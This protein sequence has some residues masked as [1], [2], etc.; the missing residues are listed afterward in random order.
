MNFL[1]QIAI[2]GIAIG[3][4]YSLVALSFSFPFAVSRTVN[5]SQ[6]QAVMLG[7]VVYFT[8]SKIFALGAFLSFVTVVAAGVL[9]GV[10]VARIAI[11]P[12]VEKPASNGSSGWLLSTIAIGIVVENLALLV[13]GSEARSISFGVDGEAVTFLDLRVQQYDA[14]IILVGVVVAVGLEYAI[15]T[16]KLGIIFR[17]VSDCKAQAE[18]IGINTTQALYAAYA[19]STAFAFVSGILIAPVFNVSA[20]MGTVIGVKGFAVASVAGMISPLRMFFAGIIFG[21]VEAIATGYL[22]AGLREIVG[23]SLLLI[24]ISMFPNG[25]G[26][27]RKLRMV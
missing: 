14:F 13:F 25:V 20:T 2:S 22:G 24:L 7:A 10:L 19:T 26:I 5:F 17:A 15:N 16:S 23:F 12:F 8:V 11:I 9:F 21:I 18:R 1:L 6:G 27:L 3:S 4:I